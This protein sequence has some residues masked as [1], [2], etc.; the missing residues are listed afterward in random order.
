MELDL[1]S[2]LLTL[3]SSP[4]IERDSRKFSSWG[5]NSHFTPWDPSHVCMDTSSRGLMPCGAHMLCQHRISNLEAVLHGS[6]ESCVVQLLLI[7]G[8][9]TVQTHQVRGCP[10]GSSCRASWCH[11][12][13]TDSVSEW[14]VCDDHS[15]YANEHRS[16]P[17]IWDFTFSTVS[18][19][20]IF[21]MKPLELLTNPNWKWNTDLWRLFKPR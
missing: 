14:T 10:D 13:G 2:L 1:C 7:S 19:N 6:P 9:L 18:I 16:Q 17:S 5:I 8:H 21:H 15:Q 12:H 4:G 20:G 3:S 11:N